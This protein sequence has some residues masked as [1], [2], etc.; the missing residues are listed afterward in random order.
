MFLQYIFFCLLI[1]RSCIELIESKKCN[2][3][4]RNHE[5]REYTKPIPHRYINVEGESF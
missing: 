1:I 4:M 2:T 3:L 5:G